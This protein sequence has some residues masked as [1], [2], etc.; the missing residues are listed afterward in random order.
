MPE[1][2]AHTGKIKLLLILL[3]LLHPFQNDV[4]RKRR[5]SPF[6]SFNEDFGTFDEGTTLGEMGGGVTN[7][8]K[9]VLWGVSKTWEQG[10]PFHIQRKSPACCR[11]LH[12]EKREGQE[13]NLPLNTHTE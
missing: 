6:Q 1:V 4:M 8:L 12:G 7:V 5:F 11:L 9:G 13:K 2:M 10:T 3:S